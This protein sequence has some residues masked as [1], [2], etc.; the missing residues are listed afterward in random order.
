MKPHLPSLLPAAVPA[1]FDHLDALAQLLHWLQREGDALIGA[2]P[3]GLAQAVQGK[4]E[5][6]R[7]LAS[8]VEADRIDRRTL[9]DG[10]RRANELNRRN[11]RLLAP[12]LRMNRARIE[13][14]LGARAVGGTL[15]S[16]DGRASFAPH[17]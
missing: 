17:R 1:A 6:L 13:S 4:E 3:D 8:A 14:L 16:A 12:H 2:D 7:R 5:S 10:I 15:Y 9:H 11:A